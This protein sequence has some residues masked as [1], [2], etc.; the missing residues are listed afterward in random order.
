MKGNRPCPA[1]LQEEDSMK[2]EKKHIIYLA[3][4]FL[5]SLF[6]FG[7][8]NYFKVLDSLELMAIDGM[9][10]MRNEAPAKGEM[11]VKKNARLNENIVIVGIDEQA[12]QEFG[13]FPWNR[14]VYATFLERIRPAKPAAVFIDIF[15]PE[16]SNPQADGAFFNALRANRDRSILF[17]YP[18]EN[19]AEGNDLGRIRDRLKLMERFSMENTPQAKFLNTY[20]FSALPVPEVLAN[21]RGAGH[22]TIVGD[23]DS[24]YRKLPV[25][26][27]Y[28]NR[29]YPHV[30]F[31]VA[32]EY[33]KVPLNKVVVKLG[34]YILLKDARVPVKDEFG[35]IIKY[36]KKDIRIPVDSNGYMLINFV[37][38]PREFLAQSQYFSF[39]DV[40]KIPPEYFNNKI[41]FFG[42]YAQGIIHD[43]WPTPHGIMYGIEINANACNTIIQNS[44]LYFAPKWVN[45][46]I[47]LFLGLL[48]GFLAPRLKIWLSALLMAGLIIL[49]AVLV[50]MVMFDSYSTILLFATPL[51]T[52][53]FCYI[54]TLLYRILTEEKEKKFIK[55]RF[56]NYVSPAV[57]DE[58]LKNPKALQLGG[59][60]RV[61][62]VF[63]SDIRSF[64]TI[65]EQLGEPQKLVAL[66]NE[67][68]SAMTDI[69]IQYDGTLDK[70][71]GDEIMAFWG[72]PLPQPDHAYLGCKTALAQI[73][74][75]KEV[76]HPKFVREGK[77]IL[78]IGIGLNT[79]RMTVGNMG[80]KSRMDYTLMG[81]EVNLGARLEGTNK[82]YGTVIIINESTYEAVKEKVVARELDLI[83]VKGK[84]KPVRI[85]ELM[86]LAHEEIVLKPS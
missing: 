29:I 2:F 53:I 5:I 37:G 79:G 48:I 31:L 83:R 20:N 45:F 15:F 38:Y 60:D 24:K 66:I 14:S 58:L 78:N 27:K 69:I 42:M 47:V 16:Y 44:F 12:L 35:D 11:V 74:Y 54:G 18:L 34:E 55:A 72:A 17:D 77:P 21:S 1:R 71:V 8:Y 10:F 76:L 68:L 19:Q 41:I 25:L 64:T 13:R 62:T 50:F 33:L 7:L 65:S 3:I 86:D 61:M 56:G 84:S 39:S 75:L 63:F 43:I 81:D 6:V 23:A 85:F 67:Y 51:L 59:E 82:V 22:A 32:L 80:S 49:L 52:V 70:Y 46:L 57:V 30:V 36:E 40:F 26:V 28:N 4:S 73:K 9:F